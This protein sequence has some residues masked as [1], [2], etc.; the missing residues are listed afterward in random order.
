MALLNFAFTTFAVVFAVTAY[1]QAEETL[2][3]CDDCFSQP[4]ALQYGNMYMDGQQY[5]AYAVSDK[6][7]AN[8]K[9]IVEIIP[10]S[11][12]LLFSHRFAAMDTSSY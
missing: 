12:Q 2:Q 6:K 4:T 3:N 10:T 11:A 8:V 1:A 5:G 7:T 9:L